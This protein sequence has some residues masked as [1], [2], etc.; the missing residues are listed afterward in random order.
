MFI[1]FVKNF[2]KFTV[3]HKNPCFFF[4]FF[5][6]MTFLDL[7]GFD[8]QESCD[9]AHALH[10]FPSFVSEIYPLPPHPLPLW[11]ED[12]NASH[13]PRSPCPWLSHWPFPRPSAAQFVLFDVQG[14]EVC[15]A[16]SKWKQ[17]SVYKALPGDPSLLLALQPHHPMSPVKPNNYLL[18]SFSSCIPS[19]TDS[20]SKTLWK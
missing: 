18:A 4:F 2:P 11:T 14:G 16:F 12:A 8:I 3:H 1:E 9:R 17:V 20:L 6:K 19:G 5:P 15:I 7:Q 10:P 13:L